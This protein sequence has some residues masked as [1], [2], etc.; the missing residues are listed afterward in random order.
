LFQWD[1]KITTLPGLYLLSSTVLVP[2]MKIYDTILSLLGVL[3][4]DD[5]RV[6][7]PCS[8]VA[9]RAVNAVGAPACLYYAYYRCQQ[10]LFQVSSLILITI[11]IAKNL[12]L[13]LKV[14]V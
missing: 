11:N 12:D 8:L 13:F 6:N 3:D 10:I 7:D 4:S 1:P 9:L 5:L 2:F 14:I